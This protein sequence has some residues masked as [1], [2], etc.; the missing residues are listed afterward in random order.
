MLGFEIVLGLRMRSPL[1]L[2]ACSV[3][4]LIVVSQAEEQCGTE[5]KILLLPAGLHSARSFNAGKGA[6]GSVYFYDTNALELLS[7]G[8]ILRLRTGAISDITVK[9]RP[10]SNWKGAAGT[11]TSTITSAKSISPPKRRSVRIRFKPNL[12]ACS[13]FQPELQ[14]MRGHHRTDNCAKS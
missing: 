13:S 4:C 9:L 2:C 5:I 1:L 6:I 11:A 3:V 12:L 7:Q 14:E 8:V 10:L